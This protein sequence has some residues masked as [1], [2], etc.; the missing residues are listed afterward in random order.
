M[1]TTEAN[2]K[3]ERRGAVRL[4]RLKSAKMIFNDSASVIDCR[5]RD[6]ST[7]GARL[8]CESAFACP[9]EV[10]LQDSDGN[11]V[12]CEVVWA[13]ETQLGVRFK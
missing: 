10:V 6:L 11:S 4:R 9:K 12:D 5:I 2:G 13:S 7:T 8:E 1:M 3:Q